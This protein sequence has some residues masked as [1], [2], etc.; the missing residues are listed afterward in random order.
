MTADPTPDALGVETEVRNVRRALERIGEH[1][2]P[3]RLTSVNDYDVK[4]VKIKGEF[5]WHTHPDTDELFL[6]LRG[7]LTIRLRDRD[8][9]LEEQDVFVVPRGVEHCPEAEDE[10]HA[11]LIEPRGT[12]NTGDA[13]GPMTSVLRE[14]A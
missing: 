5:V 10:V 6:V 4:V 14:L 13:G 1:W 12:L 11:L 9:V 2:Q 3:H 7:R 8:V